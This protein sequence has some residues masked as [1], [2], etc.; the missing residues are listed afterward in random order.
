[1]YALSFEHIACANPLRSR[2]CHARH[3]VPGP[4]RTKLISAFLEDPDSDV[5]DGCK[6]DVPLGPWTFQ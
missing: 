5:D 3:G 6:D 2:R 4:C 1:M